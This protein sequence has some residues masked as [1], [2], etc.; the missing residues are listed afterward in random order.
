V[1]RTARKPQAQ[2]LDL[3]RAMRELESLGASLSTSYR[4]LEAR[5]ERVERELAS[6]N[7]ELARKVAELDQ[8]KP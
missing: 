5:A 3:G 6:A 8:L 7:G 2:E 4:A 1:S